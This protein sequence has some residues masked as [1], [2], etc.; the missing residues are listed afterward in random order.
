MALQD[1]LKDSGLSLQGNGFDPQRK[2]VSWGY[3][4]PNINAATLNPLD[5]KLSGL[6]NTYDIDSNPKVSVVNFNTSKLYPNYVP[7]ESKLDELDTNPLTPKNTRAG[8]KGSVV[9]QIYKSSTGQ[10]Y[11][12]KGPKEGRY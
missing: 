3:K 5:P 6:Q 7:A 10:N 8:E 2:E 12:D 4:N 11:K 1:K 9:S